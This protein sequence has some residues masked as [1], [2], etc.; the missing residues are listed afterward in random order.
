IVSN[1][2]DIILSRSDRPL[3]IVLAALSDFGARDQQEGVSTNR[4]KQASGRVCHSS[5]LSTVI[6]RESDSQPQTGLPTSNQ[7]VQIEDRAVLPQHSTVKQM[8]LAGLR[9]G[10]THHLPQRIDGPC[11]AKFVAV[12]SPE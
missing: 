3:S 12:Q 10:L 9:T 7:A 1:W 8:V 4:I 2:I 11:I 6:D 5:D